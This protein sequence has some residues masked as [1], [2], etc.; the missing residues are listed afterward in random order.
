MSQRNKNPTNKDTLEFS[1]PL[2]GIYRKTLRYNN[3]LMLCFFKLEKDAKIPLH[4]HEAQQIGYVL[5]GKI[6]FMT[7]KNQNNF[8]A[9]KGDSYIFDSHEKH[10]A[11]ILNDAEV[12]EVFHPSREDYQ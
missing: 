8:I 1:N 6:Q 4:H 2:P 11:S 5:K 10:G 3:D 7:E 9:I 12:V